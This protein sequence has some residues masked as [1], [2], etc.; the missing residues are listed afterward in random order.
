MGASHTDNIELVNVGKNVPY[1]LLVGPFTWQE[2]DCRAISYQ[3]GFG[4]G[5]VSNINGSTESGIV[6]FTDTFE[7]ESANVSCVL[8]DTPNGTNP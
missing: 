3:T 4:S 5:E 6:T 1:S 8:D 7:G 2:T